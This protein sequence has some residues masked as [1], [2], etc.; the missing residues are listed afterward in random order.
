VVLAASSAVW[1]GG[2]EG[3]GS[4]PSPT[5]QPSAN[6]SSDAGN[7]SDRLTA[8]EWQLTES[9]DGAKPPGETYSINFTDS[10]VVQH[11]RCPIGAYEVGGA[12]EF[13]FTADDTARAECLDGVTSDV[14]T[15]AAS[16]AVASTL[17]TATFSRSDGTVI[18]VFT[19]PLFD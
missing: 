18:G 12:G 11:L 10:G 5:S 8:T 16:V 15:Q 14:L 7:L 1:T 19:Q 17:K 13:S 6:V 3:E 9:A 2:C 4:S